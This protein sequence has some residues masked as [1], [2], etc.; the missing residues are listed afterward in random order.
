MRNTFKLG[1][2]EWQPEDS[3]RYDLI[4]TQLCVGYLTGKELVRYLQRCKE[5]LDPSAGDRGARIALFDVVLSVCLMVGACKSSATCH[6]LL[7][8][9]FLA[10]RLAYAL[11]GLDPG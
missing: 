8:P 7:S 11:G 4:W 9:F 10:R 3:A 5:A 1:L 6:H 2:E